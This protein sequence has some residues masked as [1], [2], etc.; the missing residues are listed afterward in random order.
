[1]IGS[2]AWYQPYT[3]RS[4]CTTSSAATPPSFNSLYAAC[5]ERLGLPCGKLTVWRIVPPASHSTT[6]FLPG[7]AASTSDVKAVLDSIA[8]TPLKE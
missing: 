5:S 8:C 7:A 1:M 6:N 3:P 2:D 4:R